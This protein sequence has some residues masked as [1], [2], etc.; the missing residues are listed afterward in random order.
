MGEERRAGEPERGGQR[1]GILKFMVF[2][3]RNNTAI[4]SWEYNYLLL[5]KLAR[6]LPWRKGPVLTITLPF[7][8]IIKTITLAIIKIIVI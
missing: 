6:N 1:S 4:V 2:L 7:Q 5:F 8:K 3:Q